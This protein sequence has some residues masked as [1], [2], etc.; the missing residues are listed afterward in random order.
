MVLFYSLWFKWENKTVKHR[1]FTEAFGSDPL[2][3]KKVAVLQ[4]KVSPLT[5]ALVLMDI[6]LHRNASLQRAVESA[7]AETAYPCK[8]KCLLHLTSSRTWKK[9]FETDLT[10]VYGSAIKR[11]DET[12]KKVLQDSVNV[13]VNECLKNKFKILFLNIPNI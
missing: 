8:H 3:L 5:C 13:H 2:P 4:W 10:T 11:S 1:R 7:A 12:C 9:P 6:I